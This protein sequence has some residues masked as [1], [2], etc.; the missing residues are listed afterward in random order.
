MADAKTYRKTRPLLQVCLLGGLVI[1]L[2]A[3]MLAGIRPSFNLNYSAW[4]ATHIVLVRPATSPG[5]FE[6]VES[7]KGDLL[8]GEHVVVPELKPP[9]DAIPISVYRQTHDDGTLIYSSESKATKI[10]A[11]SPELRM[12]LFLKFK[13]DEK[14]PGQTRIDPALRQWKSA[15]AFSDAMNASVLWID[16]GEIYAFKQIMNPGPSV[17]VKLAD[18]SGSRYRMFSED[19]VKERTT[20]VIKIQNELTEIVRVEDQSLRAERLKPYVRSEIFEASRF[21]LEE[22]GKAGVPA[23]PT[24]LAMLDDPAFFDSSGDLV[25]VLVEAGGTTVGK[26]LALHLEKQLAF[27]RQTGP[28]LSFGWWNQDITP[29]APLRQQYS[30]TYQLLIALEE[31]HYTPALNTALEL[32]DFWR[33]LPQLNQRS[34]LDQ[35]SNEADSLV[36]ELQSNYTVSDP[37]RSE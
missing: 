22:L 30:Q 29:H 32:R 11:N 18:Y 10:P 28:S 31:I 36:R 23:V 4:D 24:I 13:S 37:G 5:M 17:L 2:C 27:W 20:E 34:G 33:S 12:V 3:Q 8:P 35:M 6:V 19:G 7:W 25:K 16:S 15:D 1:S 21:A 9:S 14:T 26:D